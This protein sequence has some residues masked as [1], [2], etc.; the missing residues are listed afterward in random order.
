MPP[1]SRRPRLV[2]LLQGLM[3]VAVV[4]AGAFV[5]GLRRPQS[6]PAP[7]MFDSP[8][9]AWR[10]PRPVHT[11]HAGMM[12]GPFTDGPSVTRACLACHE[13]A[14]REVLKTSHFTWLGSKASIPGHDEAIE[15]IAIGKRNL[16]NNF[17]LS[18]ESNWPRCTACHAG[19]GWTDASFDFNRADAVDCLVCHEQTGTYRKGLGGLPEE[20]TDLMRIAASVG[21]PTRENCGTCHFAGGGG[22]AVKHGDLDGTLFFPREH[23]DL[24]MG[25][26]NFQCVDCHRTEHHEISGRSISVSVT[27]DGRVMCEDCHA[28]APHRSAQLN[29]HSDAVACETC[30]I[31]EMAIDT[32]TK[33][34]WDWSTAGRDVAVKDPHR[35]LKEKGSFVYGARVLPEYRWWNGEAERYLKRDRIDPTKVVGLNRPRGDIDDRE[36]KIWPFKVHRGKQPYDREL[37]HLLVAKTYG[38]GGFWED[39]DWGKALTLGSKAADIPFSGQYG[40]AETEM[41]W[42]LAHMVQPGEGALQ[43]TDCHSERGEKG[44]LDWLALG[45]DGDPAYRG[46]PRRERFAHASERGDR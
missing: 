2:A 42:P 1:A 25:R 45:F 31:P 34:V 13:D 43:C 4:T 30:H 33:L 39:Y 35:Y 32:P 19:Y 5:L 10:R 37:K 24:H 41:F 7:L 21:A 6:E 12:K 27:G 44:R 36:A 38:P 17:C 20:G 29:L 40:F 9:K 3:L 23:V 14:G 15:P 46:S 8:S 22:D 11:D 18:I 28:S 26:E 16:L